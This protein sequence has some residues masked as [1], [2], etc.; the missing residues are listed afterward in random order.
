MDIQIII[1]VG[2]YGIKIIREHIL[3]EL[4]LGLIGSIEEEE[5]V[6]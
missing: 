4:G 5:G 1:I 6:G 3:H 2:P